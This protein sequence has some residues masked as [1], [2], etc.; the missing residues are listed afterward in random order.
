[1]R[2][3]PDLAA[4]IGRHPLIGPIRRRTR[5]WVMAVNFDGAVLSLIFG[6]LTFPSFQVTSQRLAVVI[7]AFAAYIAAAFTIGARGV[8]RIMVSAVGWVVSGVEPSDRERRLTLR[9]PLHCATTLF[10]AWMGAALLFSLLTSALY[11]V[12]ALSVARIAATIALCGLS[13]CTLCFL[14]VERGMRPAFALAL[15]GGQP[16]VGHIL[17]VAPRLVVLW[18]F[19]SGIPLL[20]VLLVAVEGD[21]V[22]R[23]HQ[24]LLIALLAAVG[25]FAGLLTTLGAA[26]SVADPLEEVR[27]GLRRVQRGHLED[28]VAV[29][30]AGEIGLV[31]SGFNEMLRGLR[32]RERLRDLFGRH[33]GAE[34]AQQALTRAARLGGERRRLSAL[35][36]DL[37]GSTQLAQRRPPEEVVTILNAM[38]D[39]VVRCITPEGG[40]VNKFEGDAALCVFGAPEDQPDHGARALRAARALHLELQRLAVTHPGLDAGIGVSSGVALAGNVG[41]EQRY[42]YTVIGDPVNEAARLS[43]VAKSSPERLLASAVSVHEAGA[44]AECWAPRGEARLRGRAEATPIFAPVA[45]AAEAAS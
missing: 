2:G 6:T 23:G 29:D 7:V 28:D 38:F 22:D 40:W 35:F 3:Q 4:A 26:R 12:D 5:L 13:T 41:A 36:V 16:P 14:L 39:A 8:T 19:G 10:V 34:V 18:A 17:G 37:R 24:V 33:V 25:I 21:T 31:Q 11:G 42:E 30:D 27:S 1:M 15:R 20:G 32:E 45:V 43:E 9:F 44:E